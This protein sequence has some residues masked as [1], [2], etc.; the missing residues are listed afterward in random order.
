[1]G[2]KRRKEEHGEERKRGEE[3]KKRIEE[4]MRKGRKR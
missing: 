4:G 3:G 2:K 1:M